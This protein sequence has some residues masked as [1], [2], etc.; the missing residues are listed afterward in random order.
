[1]NRLTKKMMIQD[2]YRLVQNDA[3]Y[4]LYAINKLGKLEDL[5]DEL[6]C[7]L[8][9]V[10]KALNEGII[11]NEEGFVNSAYDNKTFNKENDSYY[12]DLTLYNT[13]VGYYFED[14]SSPYGDPECGDI[15]CWVDLKDY[16]KTWWLKGEKDDR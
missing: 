13:G 16:Q 14:T 3:C 7:P 15:G 5:E 9:V 12:D 2:G 4:E 6:G 8:E 11:I 1:M 10:F